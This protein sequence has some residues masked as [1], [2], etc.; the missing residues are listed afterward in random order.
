MDRKE[1]IV[2]YM[3]SKEYIPLM[4]D[5]LAQVLCVPSE[6]RA[7]FSS[8]LDELEQNGLII[9][10][11]K[12][13]YTAA[14]NADSMVAGRLRC[15]GRGFFAFLVCDDADR[16]DVYINGKDLAGAIDGDRVTVHIDGTD[17]R[18]GRPEGHVTKIL[19]RGNEN[20]TG[21]LLERRRDEFFRVKCD[22]ERIY[23]KIRIP[24]DAVMDAEP[25]QRVVVCLTK[26]D[27]DAVYGRV[28]KVLGD[29]D[30][31]SGNIEAILFE[32]NIRTEF[33]EAV[34]REAE[35]TPQE[36]SKKDIA[37]R[38]DLRDKII[39]TIDGDDARDFDDAVSLDILESGNYR[40][41]VHIADVTHYVREGSALD[42]EA[43]ARGTSV[44]LAD[45]VVPMLPTLLSNGICSLNPQVD[46]LTL[47]VFMEIDA[48]GN[49]ISHELAK[50][51]IRSVERMTYNDVTALIEGKD[52]PLAK[53]YSA[54]LPTIRSMAELARILRKKRTAR[55]SL[56]FDFP[57][58]AVVVNEQGEPVDI[59]H[60]E[61]GVSNRLIEEFMLVAN[62]TIAE[63]A[64]WA[65]LP[66][67]Y[68]VH[69]SPSAEKMAEFQTFISH[70]GLRLKGTFDEENPIHPKELQTLLKQI[71]DT[72]EEQMIATYMLRSLM[73]ARYT[74][75]NLGHFGLAAKYYAHFTS[76]IRR[77]PDLSIHRIL[78][79]FLDGKLDDNRTQQ[80]YGFVARSSEQSSERELD[81]E[82]AERDV[83]SLMKAIYMS[84]FIGESFEA[85]V[86][87]VTSFGI[88]VELENSV[89]GLIRM[90]LLKDDYYDF[91]ENQM[92]LIGQRTNQIY[93]IGDKV[94]VTLMR[95]DMTA[96]Q[97]DFML[98]K[99][100]T[101]EAIAAAQKKDARKQRDKE[102]TIARLSREKGKQSRRHAKTIRR[103]TKKH[104]RKRKGNGTI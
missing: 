22:N 104:K 49:V 94:D 56:D 43:F 23:T 3:K 64:F 78:K 95:T 74:P 48:Q 14:Q 101:P 35:A 102:R 13:R 45:R 93:R 67:V 10:S 34:I 98:T 53:R 84:Q 7:A 18:T 39:F 99:D 81:A 8:L 6:D 2:S 19:E 21:I 33:P 57:E 42:T 51:V 37:G 63:Y 59:V 80:L 4:R 91:D 87:G 11:K 76:P 38:L 75:Q 55:G 62:E 1:K 61:R 100:A 5:E 16:P 28:I 73:K 17:T 25:G 26:Y 65:E 31:I 92:C 60:V 20:V 97:I 29:A 70:F 88:F 66:F 47:S 27:G 82:Y 52:E 83:D 15:N 44:Y 85:T 77:Y 69:E 12:G 58:S 71:K 90:E 46:R 24:E 89:E 54:I 50:A 30:S 68:R 96:R 36:V 79:E 72:P 40:L 9:L 103:N 32:H 86:S 41:G